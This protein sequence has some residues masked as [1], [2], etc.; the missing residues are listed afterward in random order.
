MDRIGLSHIR[1]VA[2]LLASSVALSLMPPV[3]VSQAAGTAGARSRGCPDR[4]PNVEVSP[5]GTTPAGEEV[6]LYTLS[7]SHCVE[8]KIITYG[9]I[10]QALR[11]PDRDG[12]L[13]NVVLGFDNLDDY[14]NNNSPY[15][16]AIIGRYAN[17]IAEGKFTLD[18]TTYR[19]AVNNPPNALHGGPTGF[20]T[21]VWDGEAFVRSHRV[22]VRLAYT[23]PDGEEGYPGTLQTE[24]VYTLTDDNALR[25]EYHATT[26]EP[27]IV[28][29]TNHSYFNL[30]GE[31]S[32]TIYDHVLKISADRYTPVDATLI[33]TGE[34]SPVAGTPFDFRRP[35]TI[36]ARIRADHPQIL[37]GRGYDHN[38]VLKGGGTR[39]T[40]AAR[41]VDP[42]SG[43]VLTI[44]TTEPGMQFY[45]GNFLDGT[46]VGTSGHVYRQSDGF[47]LE[48][49]HY[50]DSPNQPNFPSTVLRPG[51]E[52]DSTTV[53]KFSTS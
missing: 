11:V 36:G 18:G 49:Q 13:R 31:G 44:R 28:N 12:R 52:F 41:V 39:P 15:F 8:V 48:T 46:L 22:G 47:A 37:I 29:L 35:T 5:F 17:R 7:N 42:A 4:Q 23:S 1:T 40:L 26:D 51:E 3:S 32:G 33:P 53:F 25:I 21:K 20:H 14:V 2:A 24:V 34:L 43:R 10:V 9:G 38:F 19:L 50:P 30:E 16:G 6:D 27:T 45:S